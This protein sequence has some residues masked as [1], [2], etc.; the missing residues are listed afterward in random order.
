MEIPV[1]R[2][3]IDASKDVEEQINKI[4]K[5]FENDETSQEIVKELEDKYLTD[6][7]KICY[8]YVCDRLQT[9]LMIYNPNGTELINYICSI[10]LNNASEFI[11]VFLFY[12]R[13]T[14]CFNNNN[15]ISL[16][17]VFENAYNC[18]KDGNICVDC[19]NL[20]GGAIMKIFECFININ[21][22]FPIITYTYNNKKYPV[23]F[24]IALWNDFL[25][26]TY[27]YLKVFLYENV[28][29]IIAFQF[30]EGR[31]KK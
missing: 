21:C 31:F 23:K 15:Y 30:C 16:L 24:E 19:D 20:K 1:E 10:N 11:K 3:G 18:E 5:D 13:H 25:L 22:D 17:K 7:N 8:E 4:I 2:L 6:L 14:F 27:W 9:A 29:K 12:T 26:L 28:E